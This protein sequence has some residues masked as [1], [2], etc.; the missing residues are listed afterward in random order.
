MINYMVTPNI[1]GA[2]INIFPSLLLALLSLII[3]CKTL[4]SVGL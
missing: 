2:T 3:K 1:T 4:L